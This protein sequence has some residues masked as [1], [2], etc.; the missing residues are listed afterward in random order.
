MKLEAWIAFGSL[1]LDERSTPPYTDF[2]AIEYPARAREDIS[3][4][5][6][7]VCLPI[8]L[9]TAQMYMKSASKK[10]RARRLKRPTNPYHR[11]YPVLYVGEGHVVV[12]VVRFSNSHVL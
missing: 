12:A 9:A 11:P 8:F 2:W 7:A 10:S 3:S 1:L 6:L 5:P 4:L